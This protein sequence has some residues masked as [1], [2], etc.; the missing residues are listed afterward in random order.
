MPR[1]PELTIDTA[2]APIRQIMEAQQAFFGFVLN[3]TKVM[4]HCPT[5]VEG[6]AALNR[7]I[8]KAGNIEA[9]LRYLLYTYVASLNG[10]PF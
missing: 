1:L 2:P 4:G 5:I 6:M 10:C 8:D 9:R 3:A 7:G